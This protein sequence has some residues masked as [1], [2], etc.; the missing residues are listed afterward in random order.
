M[1]SDPLATPAVLGDRSLLSAV[2]WPAINAR[3]SAEQ[4]NREVHT[5]PISLYRWWARRPHALIGALLDAAVQNG[6]TCIADPFSGG[7]TV[8]LEA[9][10]R[11][12]AVHAQ[13][14]HPWAV[15]G[16]RTALDDVAPE[17]VSRAAQAVLASLAPLRDELYRSKCPKH[18]CASEV[19][20]AFWV[21]ETACPACTA[22]V[23]LY[24]Y[25]L[26]TRAS[27]SRDEPHAYFG[28]ACCGAVTRSHR[29]SSSRQCG[30]CGRRLAAPDRPLTADRL[31][32]CTERACGHQFPAFRGEDAW[33]LVLLQRQCVHDGQTLVHFDRP[34]EADRHQ[35]ESGPNRLVPGLAEEIPVGLETRV[36]R[37]AGHRVWADLYAP[38][39]L[40]AMQAAANVISE[41]NAS[42]PV[43]ARLRLA[44]CGAG[45]MAGRL[46]RWDRYYPKAFEA[47]ANHRFAV[48]GFVCETN[49]FADRGRGTLPRRFAASVKAAEWTREHLS[50]RP[51]ARW[52]AAAGRRHRLAH[53]TLLAHGSSER[54]L[55]ADASVDVVLTDPPYF[56]D[57]QYG[58]L[59]S[60]FLIWARVIN[61]VP[62]TVELDLGSEAVANSER[63]HDVERYR[64]L[65]SAIL[66]ETRRTLKDD[67]RMLL[68]FHN[69]D[70][71]A[72]WALGRAL[73]DAKLTVRALAV[74]TAENDSDHPKRGRLSFT[75]DLVIECRPGT[76]I[77]EPIELRDDPDAQARELLTAGRI[78]ATHGDDDLD[79]FRAAF[80][81]A[82]G[83]VRPQ[84]ISPRTRDPDPRKHA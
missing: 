7:G 16:L 54:Q 38:R 26:L 12:L 62:D 6:A 46:S 70:L 66:R 52:R 71:R 47:I 57:V 24:P 27:R 39:Q 35:A 63:C 53:G 18:G 33:R 37:R 48:T 76:R 75:K 69:T 73:H 79:A 41:L 29:D 83:D 2:D 10:R 59:A 72:W 40:R 80:V 58:E 42:G 1:P 8:A 68:T 49:L 15:A 22:P 84:R 74:A 32:R 51:P 44:L 5:P 4:R 36:L 43:K 14:L 9:A 60:L 55:A 45:E 65:L 30:A 23:Y 19:L 61:L 56:D 21:R 17:S 20:T 67:G 82:R 11:D 28:C 3:V 13:D 34:T 31:A 64:T 77:G 50:G 81:A 78:L 25:S